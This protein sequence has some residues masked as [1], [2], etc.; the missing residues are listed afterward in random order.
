MSDRKKYYA[1]LVC[2]CLFFL[3]ILVFQISLSIAS[4]A[5]DPVD[6]RAK[7][8]VAP[9]QNQGASPCDVSWAFAAVGAVEGADQIRTGILRKLSEQQLLDCDSS[10]IAF[11]NGQPCC[12]NCGQTACAFEY[13]EAN[14]SCSESSYPYTGPLC[15]GVCK[16]CTVVTTITG[17]QRITPGS[18]SALVSALNLAPVAARIEIGNHGSQLASYASYTGGVFYAPTFDDTVHQ[19]VLLV[20]YGTESG[21]DYYI[22]KN[23]LGTSWGAQGYIFLSRNKNNNLGVANYAYIVGGNAPQGTC[24]IGN[25]NDCGACSLPDGSCLEMSQNECTLAQGSY[26]GS[27]SFCIAKCSPVPVPSL[28]WTGMIIMS[29]MFLVLALFIGIRRSSKTI[30]QS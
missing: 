22:A 5:P 23:S 14:G 6:W 19:W 30:D 13:I 4:V 28:V 27:G 18:E 15:T 7:G 3:L 26:Q 1:P 17:F 16:S 29:L 9:V 2:W 8:A 24:F 20:G 25:G 21:E 11:P 10:C 12:V